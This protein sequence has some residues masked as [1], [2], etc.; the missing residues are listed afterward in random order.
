MAE[1]YTQEAQAAPSIADVVE[2]ARVEQLA[3]VRYAQ[4]LPR[5]HANA[6]RYEKLHKLYAPVD[7]DQWPADRVLRPNKIHH[8]ANMIRAFVDTEARLLSIPP[9]VTN[10]PDGRDPETAKRAE[11]CEEL[12]MR[13]LE[14]SGWDVWL[15]DLNRMKGIYSIGY[16]KPFW[17]EAD[18]RPDV[19]L[20]EQPQNLHVGW[21]SS[22]FRTIDWA[23]Y[24]Y[25]LSELEVMSRYPGIEVER[26]RGK[27][28]LV[29]FQ[30]STDHTD[31]LNQRSPVMSTLAN[32]A[33]RVSGR[34]APG[35]SEY[36]S[37][38]LTVWDYWYRKPGG[39]VCNAILVQGV[40][41]D[42][43]HEH[44]E[45]PAIPYI[46]VEHD[47][48]PGSPD[49][50]STAELLQDVQLGMNRALSHAAQ[51]L[52]DEVD[53]AYQLV[54]EN[55]D[56]VPEGLIPK[57]GE[58][59]AAGPGNEIRPITR[60][61]N[62]FPLE[63]LIDRYWDTAHK[64]TGLS[65]I[66]FGSMPG[67][68]TS[69]RAVAVQIEAAIN[70]LHS[71]RT[72]LYFAL[73]QLLLF[74]GYMVEKKD[75]TVTVSQVAEQQGAQGPEAMA[76]EQPPALE[77]RE[78]H[79]KDIIKGLNRWRIVAPEIT[80]KDV[81]EHT[82][83]VLNLVNGK[84]MPLEMGMDEV[85][86]ENPQQALEMIRRESSDPKIFPERAQAFAAVQST[87]LALMQA[88]QQMQAAGA[89]QEAANEG[90]GAQTA[91][92]QADQRAQPTLT[93][94]QNAPATQAGMAPPPG[95]PAPVGGELQMLVR[96]PAGGGDAQAMSQ[97]ALQREF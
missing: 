26:R 94:D 19:Q 56:S 11:V 3:Q 57:G 76:G 44:P 89:A 67:S 96:Q 81:Q 55:A 84:L 95:A 12:F 74:W 28:P 37:Q 85:G 15:G 78:I 42:G 27:E 77:T 1:A 63:A 21:G 75:P 52:A 91:A 7:G 65:E 2:R 4:S 71:K 46:P 48:E 22:D 61:V 60:G 30:Q 39:P 88:M 73:R 62:H 31:P 90:M 93:E 69:G 36:E 38:H 59:V 17:N 25:K 23:I 51:Y 72:R 14:A 82:N 58:I 24:A 49:G 45:L 50:L 6:S 29:H 18:Q 80:P 33:E 54:G 35:Q 13:W 16:L 9:R 8:T 10:K 47:H 32:I 20:I 64:I 34:R 41:V 79:M 87:L 83:N 97:I 92:Q 40:V 70:R 53:T 66:L 43:P 5:A 86:I 68:Q